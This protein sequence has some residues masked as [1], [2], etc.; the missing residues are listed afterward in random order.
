MAKAATKSPKAPAKA[1]PA[2]SKTKAATAITIDKV[3]AEALAALEAIGVDQQL[4]S[5][6]K[7]CLGSY[8]SDNNPVG[9]FEM[10]ERALVVFKA[11]KEKKTKGVTAKL[12][13][14]LE[15]VLKSR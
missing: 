14:D 1:T 12:I 7:W 4:Q 9:L 3:S 13:G 2:K 8:Q 10:A 5:D 11:E 15:K 6:I